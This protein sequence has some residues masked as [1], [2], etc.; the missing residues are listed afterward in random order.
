MNNKLISL[1]SLFSFYRTE[2]SCAPF[3]ILLIFSI[4][5]YLMPKLSFINYL[6]LIIILNILYCFF[7]RIL[8]KKGETYLK[9]FKLNFLKIILYNLLGFN[10]FLYLIILLDKIFIKEQYLINPLLPSTRLLPV[11]IFY[12]LLF[13]IQLFII[14]KEIKLSEVEN[15]DELLYIF[16]INFDLSNSKRFFYG[17]PYIWMPAYLSFLM[18]SNSLIFLYLF[19]LIINPAVVTLCVISLI[20]ATTYYVRKTLLELKKLQKDNT[21]ELIKH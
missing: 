12:S 2:I 7:M 11:L 18:F 8:Y 21:D 19:A 16:S 17:L 1:I 6:F 15:Y 10:V 13:F 4:P 14:Y 20:K 3:F 5:I 9:L